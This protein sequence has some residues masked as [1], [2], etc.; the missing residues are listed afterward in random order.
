MP[1]PTISIIKPYDERY[2]LSRHPVLYCSTMRFA[3]H[4][5]SG[6]GV[7]IYFNGQR[8]FITAIRLQILNLLLSTYEAAVQRNQE[9]QPAS[10]MSCG[11][12]NASMEAANKE[13]RNSSIESERQTHQAL[14]SAPK[15]TRAGRKSSLAWGQMVAGR[16]PRDQQS[17]FLSFSNNT[18]VLQRDLRSIKQLI[19]PLS[20]A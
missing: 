5:Q 11:A 8:H 3:K 10:R 16:R 9:T 2:L 7:E 4:D 20:P 15:P 18:F 13:L 1:A 14:K 12:A 6:M 17:P 19:D